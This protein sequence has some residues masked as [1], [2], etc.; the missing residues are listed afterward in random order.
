MVIKKVTLLCLLIPFICFN[1]VYANIV[2]DEIFKKEKLCDVKA[3]GNGMAYNK[4]SL[5][6]QMTLKKHTSGVAY[7][8]DFELFNNTNKTLAISAPL[9]VLEM[10]HLF[11][12]VN[13]RQEISQKPKEY[14]MDGAEKVKFGTFT[15]R[16]GARKTW[17][18]NFKDVL[19][20]NDAV[21]KQLV[22]DN[23]GRLHVDLTILYFFDGNGCDKE[24]KMK[25]IGKSMENV[26]F[27]L[28]SYLPAN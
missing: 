18:V 26:H 22:R 19:Q 5:Q 6:L 21:K 1:N 2:D 11:I 27:S 28:E 16:A 7:G 24:Y 4:A 17:Q 9:N 10:F 15:I 8:V 23:E 25:L 20:T 12:T 13:N 14:S 3:F